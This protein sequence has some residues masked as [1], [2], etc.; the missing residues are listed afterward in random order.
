MRSRAAAAVARPP[1]PR[2]PA[3]RGAQGLARFHRTATSSGSSPRGGGST[4]VVGVGLRGRSRAPVS[5][6]ALASRGATAGLIRGGGDPFT[7]GFRRRA[8]SSPGLPPA[9]VGAGF[10]EV[11]TVRELGATV[12]WGAAFASAATGGFAAGGGAGI[13]DSGSVA[14]GGS[15]SAS[16]MRAMEAVGGGA[17]GACSANRHTAMITAA[18]AITCSQT[19]THASAADRLPC[20]ERLRL[21]RSRPPFRMS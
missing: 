17:A 6:T 15:R 11:A 3:P 14:G 5:T 2:A 4:V 13:V 16:G 10:G 1:S 19:H 20:L 21:I 12:P 9:G 18:P 8:G 7:E